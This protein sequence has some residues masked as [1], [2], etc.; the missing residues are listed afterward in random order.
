MSTQELLKE[1]LSMKPQERYQIVEE[2]LKSLDEP[3]ERIDALWKVEAEKRVK[4]V[5][6]GTIKTI[7]LEDIL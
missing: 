2:I 7:P 4:A 6:D 5:K 3:D 1:V